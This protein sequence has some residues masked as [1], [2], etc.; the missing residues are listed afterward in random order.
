MKK[1]I[2][3]K[4]ERLLAVMT[5]TEKDVHDPEDCAFRKEAFQ[6]PFSAK[7]IKKFCRRI[8]VK[9]IHFIHPPKISG[10]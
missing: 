9:I 10:A 3:D 7:N 2:A 8:P 5:G 4:I 1:S 6:N